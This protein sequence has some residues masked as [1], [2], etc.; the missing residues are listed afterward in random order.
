VLD[1]VEHEQELGI[2]KSQL[3]QRVGALSADP[4]QLEG[5][6]DRR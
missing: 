4:A 1:V 6:R 5:V 3:E 2:A